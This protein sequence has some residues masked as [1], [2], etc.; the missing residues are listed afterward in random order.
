MFVGFVVLILHE[1]GFV[2][3]EKWQEGGELVCFR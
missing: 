1:V 3:G 2:L